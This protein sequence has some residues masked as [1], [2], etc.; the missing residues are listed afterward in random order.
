MEKVHREEG[1]G[2]LSSDFSLYHRH[3]FPTRQNRYPNYMYII[4]PNFLILTIRCSGGAVGRLGYRSHR[5]RR[6]SSPPPRSFVAR[7]PP[8]PQTSAGGSAREVPR[9]PE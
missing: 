3:F 5:R 9:L 7:R 6:Y 2:R 8:V 1:M 4:F